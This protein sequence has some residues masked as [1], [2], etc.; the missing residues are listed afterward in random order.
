MFKREGSGLLKAPAGA[1]GVCWLVGWLLPLLVVGCSA[2]DPGEEP[3]SPTQTPGGDG[4]TPTPLTSPTPTE[5]PAVSPTPG[6]GSPTPPATPVPDTDGDG[7]PDARDNCPEV[8]SSSQTDTDGDGVGDVCELCRPGEETSDRD[9]DGI[10]DCFDHC[11]D[12]SDHQNLDSDG[13]GVGDVCDNCSSS[14]NAGQYDANG[15]GVGEACAAPSDFRLEEATVTAI[16]S[17]LLAGTLTCEGLASQYLDRIHR[18]DLDISDGPPLNALLELDPLL[19]EEARALD[20]HLA[21]TGQ[22]VGPLHCIPLLLKDN[23]DSVETTTTAGT[24]S[25]LGSQPPQDGFAVQGIR[26]AGALILGKASMDELAFSVNGIS[27]RNGRTGNAFEPSYNSG[28]SSAGTSVAL[29]ANFAVIGTGTDNCASLRMPAAYNGLTSMRPST[30]LISGNGI[31]PGPTDITGVGGPMA[32]TVSDLAHL[33]DAMTGA[34]PVDPRTSD[35]ELHRPSS[36]LPF[37]DPHGLDGKRIGVLRMA[38]T[39]DLFRGA[40]AATLVLYNQ[41]LAV[42]KAQ[43][44]TIIDN[45]VIPEF[46][47]TNVG[48][49]WVESVDNYLTAFDAPRE[50]YLEMCESGLVDTECMAMAQTNPGIDSPQYA[51]ALVR[52][53]DNRALIESTLDALHLDALFYPVDP[54]GAAGSSPGGSTCAVASFSGM[55]SLVLQAGYS[56]GTPPMP[57]GIELLAR[58]FEEPTLLQLGY[59]FEQSTRWRRA[60]VLT[61]VVADSP[62]FPLMDIAQFNAL[63]TAIGWAAFDAFLSD[64]K[65]ADLT[66]EAFI[67]VV[68]DE[69]EA[70]GMTYLLGE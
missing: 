67:P 48:P 9:G 37:L 70:A 52:F 49:G 57:V 54:V 56:G 61:S 15:D 22:L 11:P 46:V 43:G 3:D 23:Y 47:G 32:R 55:P 68:R 29:S 53:A 51:D 41:A 62:T 35:P 10:Q 44:A 14:P 5:A 6:P 64:G 12:Q 66:G 50:S 25:L 30:G 26:R 31:F 24:L 39:Q 13:D 2:V 33:L 45:V 58:K 38:G 20:D 21:Q 42:M 28:G 19:L 7:K 60:P 34:D 65:S 8:F 69:I 40:D 17:A 4:S 16:H 59:A 27:G 1:A 63:H 18:Y 36:Y